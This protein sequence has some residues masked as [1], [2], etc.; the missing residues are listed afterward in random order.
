M[1]F[2]FDSHR[3]LLPSEQVHAEQ[4]G[5][6]RRNLEMESMLQTILVKPFL[7]THPF[8]DLLCFF[9]VLYQ[10]AKI[11]CLSGLAFIIFAEL[12]I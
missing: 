4:V 3:K 10:G 8:K 11:S 6:L 12:Q 2:P 9:F 1:Y 7:D 5:P